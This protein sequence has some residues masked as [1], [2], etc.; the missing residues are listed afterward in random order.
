MEE[1]GADAQIIHVSPGDNPASLAGDFCRE[2][3]LSLDEY[4]GPL[5]EALVGAQLSQ[6]RR[7]AGRRAGHREQLEDV[8]RSIVDASR[9]RDLDGTGTDPAEPWDKLADTE[10]ERDRLG[11]QVALLRR[12]ADARESGT[13]AR[14]AG[15]A[16]GALDASPG[17]A[18]SLGGGCSAQVSVSEELLRVRG[19]LSDATRELED[20]R[21]RLRDAE[22]DLKAASRRERVE[23]K[24]DASF[25]GSTGVGMDDDGAAHAM[26]PLDQSFGGRSGLSSSLGGG[27]GGS[28]AAD[29]R[30]FIAEKREILARANADKRA[31]LEENRRLRGLLDPKGV[32]VEHRFRRADEEIGQLQTENAALGSARQQAELEL[33]SVYKQWEEDGRRWSA[34]RHR[35]AQQLEALASAASHAAAEGGRA[36]LL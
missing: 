4:G 23:N 32:E 15:A 26:V 11:R 20:L 16:T 27:G 3:G 2:H 28:R 35:M 24:L 25:A 13:S 7:L 14:G 8:L 19:Q 6:V 12:A 17:I 34:E 29:R 21:A 18:P 31:L 10:E 5:R 36:A 1:E 30:Q 22:E 9:K 33:Q